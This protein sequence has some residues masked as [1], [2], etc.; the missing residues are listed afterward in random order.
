MKRSKGGAGGPG[1]RLP[2]GIALLGVVLGIFMTQTAS[3]AVACSATVTADVVVLDQPLVFN[4]M[5]AQNVNGAIYALRRDVIDKSTGLPESVGGNLTAGNVALRPDKRPRPLVL[6][7]NDGQCLQVNFQNLLAPTANPFDHPNPLLAVDEQVAD[8]YAGFHP[9]GL[10]AVNS[11][12]DMSSFVG[13]NANALVAPGGYKTYTFLA[14]GEGG[15]MVYSYGA[16]FGGEASGG[17]ISNGL[18][19]VV[20]VEPK[21]A[22]FYRSQASEEEL[23]LATVGTTP[24]GQP[25]VDYEAVYPQAEPWISEGKAGLPV[26]N[27][28][29]KPALHGAACGV[30][31]QLVHN[32]INAVIAGPND[33]GSFPP[34]TYPLESQGKRNPT[35]PN[36]LESFREFTVVFHDEVSAA[37]AFPAW[38]DDPVLGHTLHGVRDSFMIN[39][40]S[41]GIGSEIIANRLG[42]GPM[43]DCLDCAYEEFFLTAFTV[44]DVGQL[45]DI[46]ANVGL[47][48]CNPGLQ[49]CDAVGPKATKAFYADDPSNVHHS[50]T[51]DFVKFRNLHAGPKEHHI[52]HLHNHQWLFNAN[53]DNSNYLDAQGVGPGSGYTYEINFGGSGNRNKTAGD[54]IYHCHFYPHF[55]QGMWEMWRIHDTAETGTQLAVSGDGMHT[56]PFA[57]KDGT[58]ASGARALPDGEIVAGTPIPAV[59]PLPGIAMAPM[60]G[61]VTVVAKA[62]TTTASMVHGATPGAVVPIGSNAKVIDRTKNPGYPFWIAGIEQTVGQRPPTPPLDMLAAA[63]G[64]DGGLPRHALDGIVAAGHTAA[65]PAY[66]AAQ[67]RLDMSKVVTR[68]K[69][70]YFAE[71]GTDIERI[72][73]AYHA[74]R[75]HPSYA[76]SLNGMA[77]VSDNFVLNGAPATAGAPYNEP[78]IDDNGQLFTSDVSGSFFDGYGG[79][80][81]Q[82]TPQFGANNP[83][84][85]K[86]ANVQIDAVFNKVGYHFP[87]ERIITLWEDVQPTIDKIRPPEPFVIRLNTYDC[88]LYLHTNLVPKDYELDDYQVRTPTDIIGQH[89]H[90]P[91]WDL[92][93][94][95]GS[96]NGWN[97]ED[98]TLSPGMVVERIEAINRWNSHPGNTPVLTDVDGNPVFN[99]IGDQIGAELHPLSHPFFSTGLDNEW[100]G[101][102]TTI[103]RWFADP[104]VNTDG[105][106]RGL[107]IIFTHDHYGPSTHQ[108]IGLYATVLVEPAQSEW[109]HNETGEKLYDTATRS[110]GGPTSWQAAIMAGDIDG[111]GQDDSYREFYFEFSDFQHAYKPGVY[112]GADASGRP[113]HV[114]PDAN[115]FRDAVNPS[116][117]QETEVLYPDMVQFPPVCPGGTPRPCPEAISADDPGFF[118]VNY[119]NEPVGYR[120]F[121]PAKLGPDGKP[122]SQ[123]DG[124]GGDL[125][126]AFQTRTDRAMAELNTEWGNTPYPP[127]TKDQRPG[128]PFTPMVRALAG[129]TVRIKIQAGAHEETHNASVH[130][131]KW[132][133]GGSGFGAAPNSG[134]RASQE[135]GI[136]E[137]FTFNTPVNADHG[138]RGARADYL[139]S[140]DSSQ[141]G[142]WSGMWGI[143]RSYRNVNGNGVNDLVKLPNSNDNIQVSNPQEF[144][145]VCPK[146]AP[147]RSYDISAVMANDVLANDLGVTLVPT[148]ESALMHVGGAI[149]PMGG[150]LVYNARATEVSGM[151]GDVAAGEIPHL[152][153]KQGPLHDPTA[154]MYVHTGDLDLNGKLKPGVPTEPVMLRAAAGECIEVTLRNRLP[155]LVPDLAGL[156]ALPP[157]VQRDP[158]DPG[159]LLQGPTSFNNNLIRPSSHVG[160]HP[161]LVEYDVTR[162]DG[163]NVGINPVQTA[164]PGGLVKYRWYAGDLRLDFIEKVKGN[165][166]KLQNLV[167]ASAVELGGGNLMPADR[168]KQGQKGMIGGLVI[169]PEGSTWVEDAGQRAAATVTKPS[170][171]NFRDFALVHQKAINMKYADGTAVGNI[172][173]EGGAIA[174]DSEDSGQAAINYASEPLWFRFGILPSTDFSTQRAIPNSHM[175]YSNSLVGAD[176]QTPIFTALTG[177][178]VRMRVLEPTG[179]GRGSVFQLQGHVWQRDPYLAQYNSETLEMI[180]PSKEIG[181]NPLGMY[182]GHQ[183]SILP[184]A[185]FDIVPKHGAGGQGKVVGDYLYQDRGSFGNL[186]GLWGIFRVE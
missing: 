62:T 11:I 43:H 40:G 1:C 81:I 85:Y 167:M 121:D 67:T 50:Y 118:V 16:P 82:A 138:Q 66:M 3:A 148:D 68:A 145:G 17:N 155:E 61:E 18:F 29:C 117:R 59:I 84:I 58:P 131:V 79:K 126:Y 64:F 135:A 10:Q 75:N 101:A 25:I 123:A 185:H 56:R 109:V 162:G 86:A 137:Q 182:L 33:D 46:P 139:Y 95:D 163:A 91:K 175:A 38:Y 21:A 8:R 54:A 166:K 78:C 156:A 103:Q 146:T 48:A 157:I 39:Y 55:A 23:R 28:Q 30:D 104:V 88:A 57:L 177:D 171:E 52:F 165:K 90:L 186:N 70:V 14:E 51:G 152:V 113:N 116:V 174:E 127:L 94:A 22:R 107:G 73:M 114:A 181:E 125:A 164:A 31:N 65:D 108:Q 69:P 179:V 154:I 45:V 74:Q 140:V 180:F 53:D 2:G 158:G 142:L 172:A 7:V 13:K 183:E 112:I 32:N 149:D 4:R 110:D 100:L 89:I 136:S 115:S 19:A 96:A 9:L 60:P 41:G 119:R 122:G 47:E 130:G 160:I 143:M 120:V 92:T 35:V 184:A 151:V 97:Y 134:W 133:Q 5:G 173:D 36:R 26:L 176:P 178:D 102:R 77:P 83:R 12:D 132:L 161:Q 128:D 147:V 34:S 15:R 124:L 105:V 169:E 93:S 6:R 76:L 141:D 170:G 63:G 72:A 71:E 168:I 150:T 98:G 153:T 144:N 37:Q 49:N 44:G 111:D 87:Q 20:N 99:S 80:G 106:D 24:A 42:V 159:D 27:L 129:D